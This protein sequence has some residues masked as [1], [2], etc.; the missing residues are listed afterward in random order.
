MK[1]K[2]AECLEMD[3]KKVWKLL[4]RRR[5]VSAV[6]SNVILT[7]AVVAVS[8]AV[9]FWT[10]YRSSAYNEQYSEAMDADIAR[11]KERLAFEYVFHH[12][13]GN[14]LLV[15]LMNC[16]TIDDTTVKTVYVT[17]STGEQVRVF[18]SV[19]LMDF[20]GNEIA[21]QDLDE[22][23]EGYFVLFSTGLAPDS[24]YSVRVVTG[25]G[26]TFDHKFVA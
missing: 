22:G 1:L 3:S 21:D 20:D 10:Q 11:L 2:S 9:L 12:R 13:S 16:G 26:S 17:T 23:E 8:F 4:Y 19:T 18:S 5:G 24:S 7:G 14:K 25:R 15:Y 6:I